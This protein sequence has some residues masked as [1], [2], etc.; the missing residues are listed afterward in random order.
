M[1]ES[2]TL[3]ERLMAA[4]AEQHLAW[5]QLAAYTGPPPP[6]LR[7]GPLPSGPAGLPM[8]E[9][10][11]LIERLI[12]ARAEQHLAMDNGWVQLAAY[13][14]PPPGARCGATLVLRGGVG[15]EPAAPP[16]R[17]VRG[18]FSATAA[19]HASRLALAVLAAAESRLASRLAG[20]ALVLQALGALM[21]ADSPLGSPASRL[22]GKRSKAQM[23]AGPPLGSRGQ[24]P[25]RELGRTVCAAS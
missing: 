10:P 1:K 12:A 16:A 19:L 15:T 22:C 6:D 2:P 7:D 8:Q 14:G 5:V 25:A 18:L 11:T 23:E 3:I 9:S 13:T 20:A 21:K 24:C 17:H 4:R